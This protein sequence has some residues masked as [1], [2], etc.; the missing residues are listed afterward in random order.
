MDES[1]PEIARANDW[2]CIVSVKAEWYNSNTCMHVFI[3]ENKWNCLTHIRTGPSLFTPLYPHTHPTR[4]KTIICQI[5]P[6]SAT[7]RQRKGL[8]F[9]KEQLIKMIVLSTIIPIT[10]TEVGFPTLILVNTLWPF[11]TWLFP[12][13]WF[14]FFNFFRHFFL[15]LSTRTL[16]PSQLL[17]V[18][19]FWCNSQVFILLPSYAIISSSV[20]VYPG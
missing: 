6:S 4:Q 17:Q 3:S 20:P 13:C 12:C 10:V 11:A 15:I 9:V 5:P 7:V 8:V 2:F 16:D 18:T 19:Q 14:V 1:Y